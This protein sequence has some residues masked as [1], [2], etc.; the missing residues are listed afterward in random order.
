MGGNGG[1]VQVVVVGVGGGGEAAVGREAS[2]GLWLSL[3]PALE[4]AGAGLVVNPRRGEVRP[5]NTTHIKYCL[6]V[7]HYDELNIKEST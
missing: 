6:F 3:W 2:R 7:C 4:E 1:G 5:L